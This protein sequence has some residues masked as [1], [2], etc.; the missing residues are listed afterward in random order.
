MSLLPLH[1]ACVHGVCM[2][3]IVVL[4]QLAALI[5]AA[6]DEAIPHHWHWPTSPTVN[7]AL[8]KASVEQWLQLRPMTTVGGSARQCQGSQQSPLQDHTN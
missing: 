8:Q 3:F 4:L 6:E 2:E 7:D 1:P 5:T